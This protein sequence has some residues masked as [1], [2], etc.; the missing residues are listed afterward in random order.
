[1]GV[2]VVELDV[3]EVKINGDVIV[4]GVDGVVVKT[5]KGE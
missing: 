3:V 4:I 1:M 5:D 2:V